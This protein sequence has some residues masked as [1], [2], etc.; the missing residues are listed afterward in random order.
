MAA[1]D[2]AR[3]D[4]I[5]RSSDERFAEPIT[6]GIPLPRGWCSNGE[7]L[8]LFD[9]EG[10]P[11]PLQSAVLDTWSDGSAKWVLLDFFAQCGARASTFYNIRQTGLLG[12]SNVRETN[13]E[14]SINLVGQEV[15]LDT[16]C[17][18]YVVGPS[19]IAERRVGLEITG[20]DGVTHFATF[21]DAAVETPG[22][23]RA[24]VRLRG[25]CRVSHDSVCVDIRL[26]FWAG[27]PVVRAAITLRN[28]SPAGHAG[29]FWE[30]GSSGS[31][32][33][34]DASLVIR[35]TP[36]ADPLVECS[37]SAESNLTP[38]TLPFGI[39]QD[40]SGGQF[41]NSTNHVDR[42]G[43][44]ATRFR[45][46][47]LWSGA[48]HSEGL[49]ADPILRASWSTGELAV[50]VPRFWQ[51]F[52][53][54]IEASANE[55]RV[56]LFPAQ[57]N[58][59]ELQG[60]EQK[61]HVVTFATGVDGAASLPLAWAR[62]PLIARA[63][64]E[65][66]A[67]TGAVPYLVPEAADPNSD[68]VE[69]VRSAIQGP[70]TFFGK[71]ETIDEYGWRNFGD[72]Y[73]DHEATHHTGETPLV[74]HYNNQY[75]AVAGFGIHYMRSGDPRWWDLLIDLAAHVVDI[76]IY[77]TTLDKSAYNGGMF[78]HT[79]HYVDAGKS[80]H[81]SYP[82][83]PG[84][85]GGGPANEH[86]YSSGLM[87][88]YFMTGDLRYREAVLELARWVLDMDDGRKTI[89]RWVDR[90]PTGLASMTTSADY[91][92]PGRGAAYS[93]DTLLNASRLTGDRRYSEVADQLIRRCIHP[94]DD[95]EARHLLDAERRWHYTVFLQML[96][97]YLDKK[98]A[99]REIDGMFAYAKAALLRYARWMADHEYPYLDKPD[100]LE[101]P[102]ETWAAQDMRKSEVF[103]H[104]ARHS[105]G[106]E[107]ARFEERADFFFRYA[108]G[109]LM[110]MESRHLTRPVV[111]MLSNGY[112][113]AWFTAGSRRDADVPPVS[114]PEFGRPSSFVPQKSRVLNKYGFGLLRSLL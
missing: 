47:R 60:G 25:A 58:T 114:A 30:L 75:D 107:R 97:R 15:I 67:S 59:Q 23:L 28:E 5:S 27:L 29:G 51:N 34:K 32:L 83:R 66:Y 56:R 36:P 45:G 57:S 98:M 93:I 21:S 39:H 109:T 113:R 49:R 108:T 77:H 11:G 104:A 106:A 91:H 74:S 35:L 78:W 111:L 18:S 68:Y 89:F 72:L 26:T 65:W 48:L 100:T 99:A 8:A 3:I 73:A 50:A 62:E 22:P 95:L 70:A 81:R 61:T 112:M 9:A 19:S 42:D 96:G 17:A 6:V 101:Y 16:G 103:M 14:I 13:R 64:P 44:V 53:R 71:R 92:G 69:L 63:T 38:V 94:D 12:T 31:R 85:G 24:T 54:A 55:I 10:A 4:V 40:S 86:D 43:R 82:R 52:P 76:D 20:V 79:A 33:I 110:S 2:Q 105:G 7:R 102:N 37:V 41:W 87:L 90:G 46:Y 1:L 80:T 88:V 84:V